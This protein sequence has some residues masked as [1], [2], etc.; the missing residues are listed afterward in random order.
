[1]AAGLEPPPL[2]LVHSHWTVDEEKMS[3]SRGNVIQPPSLSAGASIDELTAMRYFLLRT[4]T[5]HKDNSKYRH[6]NCSL[7]KSVLLKVK[8]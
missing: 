1:M 6:F 7:Q 8:M 4:G 5:P 2:L 3:K